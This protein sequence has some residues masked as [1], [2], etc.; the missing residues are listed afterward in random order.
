MVQFGVDMQSGD[1][2]AGS[3]DRLN[4]TALHTVEVLAVLTGNVLRQLW[5]VLQRRDGAVLTSRFVEEDAVPNVQLACAFR[6]K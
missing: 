6:L 1:V 5:K 3:T 2:A 4:R